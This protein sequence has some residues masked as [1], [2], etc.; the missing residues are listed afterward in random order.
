LSLHRDI[1]HAAFTDFMRI[2]CL[3]ITV[4]IQKIT[5]ACIKDCK[6]LQ[7][8]QQHVYLLTIIIIILIRRG[9]CITG[10]ID[11]IPTLKAMN[12]IT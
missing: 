5:S 3:E 4:V 12:K 6:T 1:S 8:L 7:I 2:D 10:F 9:A 11:I